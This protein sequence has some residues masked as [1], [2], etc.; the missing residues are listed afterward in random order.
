VQRVVDDL[1]PNRDIAIGS[2]IRTTKYFQ[3]APSDCKIIFDM[4]DSIGLN[5]QR[6]AKRASSLFWRLIYRLESIRLL[7][8]ESYWI[9]CS[10][11]TM[12]FNK[13]ECDYWGSYGNVCLMPHGVNDKTLC[14]DAIDTH[15]SRSGFFVGKVDYQPSIDAVRDAA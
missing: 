9:K 7:N 5:Y 15:Y 6:S 1:L 3:Y 2:L 4:I 11:A 14:Y 12:L 10:C 8:Y 13:H